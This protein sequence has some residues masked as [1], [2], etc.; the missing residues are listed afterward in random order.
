M[1]SREFEI[2]PAVVGSRVLLF[3]LV[4]PFAR[5]RWYASP[6]KQTYIRTNAHSPT[7][8][9]LQSNS[10]PRPSETYKPFATAPHRQT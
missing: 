4:P 3:Y 10:P 8:L 6:A 5:R 7:R 2:Y 1:C 9:H